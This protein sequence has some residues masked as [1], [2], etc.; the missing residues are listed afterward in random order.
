MEV[1]EKFNSKTVSDICR[2]LKETGL[3]INTLKANNLEYYLENQRQKNPYHCRTVKKYG[4]QHLMYYRLY[5]FARNVVF[6]L[7]SPLLC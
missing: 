5:T 4:S 1:F 3:G 2:Q 7:V 6:N